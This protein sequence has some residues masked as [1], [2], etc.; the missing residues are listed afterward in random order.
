MKK[1]FPGRKG[2]EKVVEKFIPCNR[3]ISET[4]KEVKD[5]SKCKGYIDEVEKVLF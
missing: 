5:N 1:M 2:N 4:R 3:K